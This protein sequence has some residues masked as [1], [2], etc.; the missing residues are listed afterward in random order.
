M[1]TKEIPSIK[2]ISVTVVYRDEK[3]HQIREADITWEIEESETTTS[4]LS[5]TKLHSALDFI[6]DFVKAKT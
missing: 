2:E 5:N 3:G 6:V 4:E 1:S